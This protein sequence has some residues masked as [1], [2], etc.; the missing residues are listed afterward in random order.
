MTTAIRATRRSSTAKT[1][2]PIGVDANL[3]LKGL[4]PF[5]G[6][7]HRLVHRKPGTAIEKFDAT[8]LGEAEVR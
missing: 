4:S 7:V 5:Q 6:L 1:D 8:F 2:G 3:R